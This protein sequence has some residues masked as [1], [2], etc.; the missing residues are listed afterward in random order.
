[1]KILINDG[2]HP[3]GKE[4]F[5]KA[6]FICDENKIPQDELAKRLNEYDAILVRSATKI[7][8]EIIDAA[9]NLKVIGRGGVGLDNIDVNYAK[10]KNIAVI[11]TPAASTRSVAELTIAHLFSIVRSL[12]NLN[13][14]MAKDGV[15]N[16]STLKKGASKGCELMEKTLGLIGFGRIGQET[17]SIALG[18]G[19][20]VIA[21]DEYVPKANVSLKLHPEYSQ[22]LSIEIKTTTKEEV[23][24]NADFISLHI[25]GGQ[26]YVL[27]KAEFDLM[28]NG[29]GIVNCSRGGTISENALIDSI[30]SGKVKFVATDVFE[31]EPPQDDAILRLPQV[32]LSPH[33]GA[34]TEEAQVRVST[35]L[36]DLVVGNLQKYSTKSH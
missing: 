34:S 28:K 1:M 8:A 22:D 4:I 18:C 35:E 32:G 2:L 9:P 15:S 33:I 3:L 13:R 5:E 21:F 10:S 17:A 12:P 16:F 11:N 36:A 19:M 25:P 6:G 27:D 14:E 24:K 7:T 31:T 20:K 29:V 23:L 30:E 26:G